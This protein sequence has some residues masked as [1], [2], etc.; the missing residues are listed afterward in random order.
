MF[1]SVFITVAIAL[2]CPSLIF[3]QVEM[4]GVVYVLDGNHYEGIPG[5]QIFVLRHGPVIEPQTTD[6]DGSFEFDF[7]EGAPVNVV[8][9]GPDRVPQLQSIAGKGGTRNE[10]HV[11]LLTVE[12][13]RDAG[14]NPQ[15]QLGYAMALLDDAGIDGPVI[16][17]LNELRRRDQ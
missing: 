17:Q 11:T 7:P 3:G 13:S 6:E 9:V 16:D 4:E 15:F 1:R 12:E 10:A 5:V 14:Q 2:A 8:F